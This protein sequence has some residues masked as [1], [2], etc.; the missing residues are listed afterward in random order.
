MATTRHRSR[1][2]AGQR[3]GHHHTGT[4]QLDRRGTCR[5]AH[6][7]TVTFPGVSFALCTVNRSA[8]GGGLLLRLVPVV[9]TACVLAPNLALLMRRPGT[10]D[11]TKCH[12]RTAGSKAR[13][14]RVAT[15]GKWPKMTARSDKQR[16]GVGLTPPRCE[17][18]RAAAGESRGCSALAAA[19]E[20]TA[21]VRITADCIRLSSTG[22]PQA[23]LSRAFF[24]TAL[25]GAEER[26]L[27][28]LRAAVCL[29]VAFECATLAGALWTKEYRAE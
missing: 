22:L 12:Q 27:D 25:A 13:G 7:S 19:T 21:T 14:S 6:L 26:P 20:R 1:R 23:G 8:A 5:D 11:L 15:Q 18:G 4:A 9:T 2:G 3:D 10:E 28:L 17:M 16:R 29:T 24:V